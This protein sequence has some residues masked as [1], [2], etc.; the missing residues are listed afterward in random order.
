MAVLY[1]LKDYWYVPLLLL[2]AFL[3]W[4]CFKS[5]RNPLVR[6]QNEIDAIRAGAYARETQQRYGL[7]EAKER[8]REKFRA[9]L[10]KL[11]EKQ[12]TQAKELEDDPV[13]LAR[14]LVRVVAQ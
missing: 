3:L 11:D 7:E 5:R 4:V 8:I 1:W 2:G 6:I 10:A 13:A 9:E 14:F 12:T